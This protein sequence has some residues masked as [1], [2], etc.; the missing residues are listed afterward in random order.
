MLEGERDAP[1]TQ[2][3]V[4]YAAIQLHLNLLRLPCD[5]AVFLCLLVLKLC[6]EECR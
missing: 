3:Q 5:C 2:T 1:I 6:G 4:I